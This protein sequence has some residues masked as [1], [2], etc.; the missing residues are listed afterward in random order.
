M[1]ENV[2]C[3]SSRELYELLEAAIDGVDGEE[4]ETGYLRYW[5]KK[6]TNR[7]RRLI[8]DVRAGRVVLPDDPSS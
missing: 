8:D 7:A 6:K 3:V 4:C 5:D 1:L 2:T